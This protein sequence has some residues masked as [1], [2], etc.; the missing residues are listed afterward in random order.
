MSL[1]VDQAHTEAIAEDRARTTHRRAQDRADREQIRRIL[2]TD[3]LGVEPHLTR[4]E[5]L[6][7]P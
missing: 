3:P 5:N 7:C 4:K 2:S 1:T 6:T